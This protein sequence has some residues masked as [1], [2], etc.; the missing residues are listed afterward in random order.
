[1]VVKTSC[2]HYSSLSEFSCV[3]KIF[4][5]ISTQRKP[6][7]SVYNLFQFV[8]LN[9]FN[10]ADSHLFTF[11]IFI[12]FE[13]MLIRIFLLT[14]ISE[15]RRL[16]N[17]FSMYLYS[18]IWNYGLY[19]AVKFTKRCHY[20]FFHSDHSRICIFH[21]LWVQIWIILFRSKYSIQNVNVNDVHLNHFEVFENYILTKTILQ[22]S[23]HR[24]LNRGIKLPNPKN[25]SGNRHNLQFRLYLMKYV[26]SPCF[27]S[28]L[29]QNNLFR[30]N[31]SEDFLFLRTNSAVSKNE[32]L[33][34]FDLV[35]PSF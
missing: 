11:I 26:R 27:P 15:R 9:F 1:M 29:I 22:K 17:Y 31:C 25:S 35:R 8:L 21:F 20:F 19:F 2:F 7:Y 33:F 30:R 5:T 16:R 18:S 23:Q 4:I 12:D 3:N 24:N 34:I 10:L 28:C 14:F 13:Y 6:K 32:R